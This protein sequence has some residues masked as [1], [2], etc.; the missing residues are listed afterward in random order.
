MAHYYTEWQDADNDDNRLNATQ[1]NK[2]FGELDDQVYA[3][4]QAIAA[5]VGYTSAQMLTDLKANDGAGSGVDADLLD[6][7]HYSEILE[8]AGGNADIAY[9]NRNGGKNATQQHTIAS[10]TNARGICM[11]S[12]GDVW[13]GIISSTAKLQLRRYSGRD[14]SDYDDYEPGVSGLVV[15]DL[16]AD[17][18]YV[19]ALLVDSSADGW[20]AAVVTS[21][22]QGK[23]A[24]INI[25]DGTLDTSW[26]SSGTVALVDS[27]ASPVADPWAMDHDQ[28]YLYVACLTDPG[29]IC[30]ITKS[31]GTCT[32]VA[33]GA[34]YKYATALCVFSSSMDEMSVA[35]GF[36]AVT[37]AATYGSVA[38]VNSALSSISYFDI[39]G[40]AADGG[41]AT[42]M[43]QV[44][45]TIC[46][47]GTIFATLGAGS[48]TLA[49]AVDGWDAYSGGSLKYSILTLPSGATL[50]DGRGIAV[51]PEGTVWIDDP[52]ANGDLIKAPT[53]GCS[54]GTFNGATYTSIG[55]GKYV[56]SLLHDGRCLWYAG[57]NGTLA[58]IGK[59]AA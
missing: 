23:V 54:R 46:A 37:G 22:T 36:H 31:S 43:H 3:N 47:N 18:D 20:A 48:D 38:I 49:I 7:K 45:R 55:V 2:R 33:F 13:V 42:D 24:R 25:D 35:V 34:Y 51:S 5:K 53:M 59:I 58:M 8:A 9:P 41:S 15:I 10:T 4:E 44:Q 17:G 11:D 29:T 14:F 21:G 40:T 19:Y 6:G 16:V 12:R 28:T 56:N 26:G 30:R 1:L 39:D 32:G 50:A 57:N 52:A 27:G